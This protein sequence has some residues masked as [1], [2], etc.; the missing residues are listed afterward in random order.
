MVELYPYLGSDRRGYSNRDA[1][2][3]RIKASYCPEYYRVFGKEPSFRVYVTAGYGMVFP[4]ITYGDGPN[5]AAPPPHNINFRF[6]SALIAKPSTTLLAGDSTDYWLE[7]QPPRR[8]YGDWYESTSHL[9]GYEAGHPDRHDGKA[10][11]CQG[12]IA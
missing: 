3:H 2:L 1:D 5:S 9:G 11:A 8:S 10:R 12:K 4:F 7:L 6:N